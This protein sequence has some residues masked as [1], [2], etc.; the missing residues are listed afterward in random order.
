MQHDTTVLWGAVVFVAFEL[1]EAFY[2]Y[3]RHTR[4]PCAY[5]AL[6]SSC[7]NCSDKQLDLKVVRADRAT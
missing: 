5:I 4:Y 1:F 3:S 6:T 2:S 7:I